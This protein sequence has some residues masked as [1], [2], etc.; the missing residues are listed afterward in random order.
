M[1]SV[2]AQTLEDCAEGNHSEVVE[3]GHAV[4]MCCR[5]LAEADFVSIIQVAAWELASKRQFCPLLP[6]YHQTISRHYK[7]GQK[8]SQ[9]IPWGCTGRL[10]LSVS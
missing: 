2:A 1:M 6:H 9:G 4:K 3:A 8:E 5:K 10:P 7:E